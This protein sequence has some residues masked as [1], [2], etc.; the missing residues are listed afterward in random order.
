[1]I[2]GEFGLNLAAT[3]RVARIRP[4]GLPPFFRLAALLVSRGAG[5]TPSSCLASRKNDCSPPSRGFSRS[6][7]LNFAGRRL[8]SRPAGRNRRRP[9]FPMHSFHYHQRLPALR[10]RRF[11]RRWRTAMARRSTSTAKATI[12]DHFTRLDAA[13]GRAR[14]PDL[15]RHQGELEPRRAQP[16]GASAVRRFRHRLGRRTQARRSGRAAM[17]ASALSPG[18]ARAVRRSARRWKRSIYCFNAESEAELRMH[19]RGRRRAR[20]GPRRWRCG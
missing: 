1:M 18:S 20:Q 16:A 15:L 7:A 12:V 6:P 9:R 19:Q 11:R 3:P 4:F 14:S 10:G 5:S 17:P 13:L 2:A 8:S